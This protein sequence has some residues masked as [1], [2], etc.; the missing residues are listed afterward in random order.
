M[1]SSLPFVANSAPVLTTMNLDVTCKVSKSN[2]T[3]AF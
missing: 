1:A 3:S 2:W